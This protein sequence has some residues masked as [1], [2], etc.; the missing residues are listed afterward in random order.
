MTDPI[1]GG[2][3]ISRGISEYGILIVIAAFFIISAIIQFYI[4]SNR[5]RRMSDEN[6]KRMS[7]LLEKV[8]NQENPKD[9]IDKMYDLTTTVN[10]LV[11]PL[12]ALIASSRE[13]AKEECTYP[14]VSRVLKMELKSAKITL[15]EATRS[16]IKKN[17]IHADES[18]T[19]EKVIRVVNTVRQNLAQ[20]LGLFK[21][22]SIRMGTLV[23]KD[24]DDTIVNTVYDFIM[25]ENRDFS[26]LESDLDLVIGQFQNSLME[27]VNARA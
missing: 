4:N 18:K 20:G 13:K 5:F 27:A 21:Y 8:I 24:Y 7:M 17:N 22:K 16:I 23:V 14:Q 3:E 11:I 6:E 25:S 12:N 1:S 26:K 10:S 9:L 2:L 19:K 15:I